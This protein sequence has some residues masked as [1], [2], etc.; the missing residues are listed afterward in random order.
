MLSFSVPPFTVPVLPACRTTA[1]LPESPVTVASPVP[2][3]ITSSP[4]KPTIVPGPV[5][6]VWLSVSFPAVPVTV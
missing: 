3:E 1:S 2:V 5:S 4:A 6:P